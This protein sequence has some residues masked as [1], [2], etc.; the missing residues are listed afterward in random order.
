MRSFTFLILGIVSIISAHAQTDPEPQR[1][2]EIGGL[3]I[4]VSRL[5][6]KLVD[7]KTGKGVEAASVQLYIAGTD[8]LV[9]GMLTPANGDFRFLNPP[10]ADSFRVVVSAIGYETWSQ[11]ISTATLKNNGSGAFEKDLG[12]INLLA[13]VKQLENVTVTGSRPALEMGI[14][15]RVFNVAKSLTATGGTAVDVMKNIP[16]VTVDIEG[17]VQLRSST[18]QIFVDGRPTILTLDQIPADNIEKVELIT[19]PSAKYDAASSGGIINVVLKKNKR[20]GLNGIAT[21]AVGSPK[22]FNSNLNLNI[23]Q[24]KVNFF[25]IGS[26]NQGGG[27]NK[28]ETE[29]ENK[30]NG[31]TKDYFNQVTHNERMRRFRSLRFGIDYFLDN[32]N[33]ISVNQD[34]GAGRFNNTET[35]N[36]QYLRGDKQLEYSGDRL[37]EGRFNV[38]RN[39]TKLNY[40]HNFPKEGQE[41]TADITYNYGDRSS[42][43]D[44]LNNYVAA[45]G[46]VYKPSTRVRNAGSSDN[47]QIT[48]QADYVHPFNDNTKLETGFRSYSNDFKSFYDAFGIDNGQETKLSLSNN[49]AYK[50]KVNAVYVTFSKSYGN[51]SFQAGLRGEHAKFDGLL[52]DSAFKF[53][54]EYPKT[55]KTAWDGIFPSLFLTQKIS[56]TDQ[57]QANF[58]R[59]IRRPDFWQ[60]NPFIDID[61]PVNLSQGNPALKPE[62]IN[63]FE[64]NYSKDY[65]SG[66]FLGAIYYRNNPDDI[67]QYSDTITAAQYAELENAGVDP[68][69]ILNT[70]ING[71]V[72]NRYGAELTVQQKLGDNFDIT[73]TVNLQY[74]TVQAAVKDVN[75]DNEGFNWEAKLTMNYKIVTK[76]PSVFNNLSFQL[77]GE[78]ESPNVI[79]QGKTKSEFDSDFA[80]RKDFLKNN[81]ATITFGI[82]D[83]FNTRRWGNI[84]DT[85][86]FYQDSYSRWSV[87]TFR[88][89][90]SYKFGKADFTLLNKNERSGGND[91]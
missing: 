91:D 14:D 54:Y 4:K 90:F 28:G 16:S 34:F 82:N 36:Q 63:S 76:R 11:T 66:N 22:V 84:Y 48:V 26:Y 3:Q 19:N 89:S 49:Y 32:R 53:G 8:S 79:P 17:N 75:L 12:N 45:D 60:I 24:G 2:P 65:S 21:V 18:P 42:N 85:P 9:D 20:T 40:K 81:K 37:T 78:Y 69:A 29:R 1:I 83:I 43:S 77:M 55:L 58:S 31:Q 35:Q 10:A 50:E 41:L 87:R 44:I 7:P 67:T 52:V 80:V 61:D 73:P 51:F 33:T 23:R 38:N 71:G 56:E 74:R 25:V 15:R 47:D 46:S 72:T 59:R 86:S 62:F 13:Q 39:S 70:F 5:Y 6:G 68:N 57:V 27:K 88:L 64:L 30:I